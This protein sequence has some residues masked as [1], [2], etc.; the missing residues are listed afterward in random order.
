VRHNWRTLGPLVPAARMVA[1][2]DRELYQP[3]LAA[4]R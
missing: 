1:D 3:M 2:Y 4:Q